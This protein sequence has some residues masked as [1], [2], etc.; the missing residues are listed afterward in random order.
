MFTGLV[1]EL[2]TVKSIV[3]N[4][5]SFRLTITAKKVPE[6]IKLGDSI[7]VNGA[8]LT[9]VDFQSTCFTCDVMP[10]TAER[11]ALAGIGPGTR[12]NL[13]RALRLG[14][15]LGGHLVSGHIDG[16]GV[17]SAKKQHDNA[18]LFS[19]ETEPD[20]MRYIVKKGS[21]AIDGVSLTVVDCWPT[22]F[23]VSVIP[24]TQEVTTLHLKTVRD[25]VNL[26]TDMIG[27]YVEKLLRPEQQSS[28]APSRLDKDLLAL[29][30]FLS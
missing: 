16:V 26:E 20:L 30:G 24:H 25:T 1:E 2:G 23:S 3:R 10:E 28:G 15:R 27:K 7:A 9:V 21:I 18:M 19:I 13:E 22:G 14:D 17:I 29:H 4:N 11:T 8:C 12:V 6:D 5:E